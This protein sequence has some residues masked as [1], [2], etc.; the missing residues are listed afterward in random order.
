[1]LK[2]C[3]KCKTWWS[4]G[5]FGKDRYSLNS[6]KSWC[7]KCANEYSRKFRAKNPDKKKEEGRI[8]RE[9]NPHYFKLWYKNNQ[10]KVKEDRRRRADRLTYHR[11]WVK[12]N[13]NYF[14]QWRKDNAAHIKE[15]QKNYQRNR[16]RTDP[17]FRA[18]S[19]SRRRFNDFI[20]GGCKS[21][22]AVRDMGCTPE[23]FK[24]YIE[25]KFYSRKDGTPMVWENY[26]HSNWHIDHIIPLSFF[27]PTNREQL[28]K[29]WHYTNLQ[30]LWAEDNYKKGTSISNEAQHQEK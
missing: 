1:M 16:R 26:G 19:N 10:D 12:R 11:E 6:L 2:M 28:L 18:L 29:A 21:V 5:Y 17:V 22:S 15:W 20:R 25:A 4:Y 23:E 30:P 13:P 24:H 8:W 27:D 3:S 7:K 9:K 14:L